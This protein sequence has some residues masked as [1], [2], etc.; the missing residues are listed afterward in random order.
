MLLLI[1]LSTLLMDIMVDLTAHST[2]MKIM[3][4]MIT[5]LLFPM[6]CNT[7]MIILLELRAVNGKLNQLKN[8]GKMMMSKY[9][10]MSNNL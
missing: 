5:I 8:H 7:L 2:E 6:R 3:S 10:K 9:H 1:L 4:F